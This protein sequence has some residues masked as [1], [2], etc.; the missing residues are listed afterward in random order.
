[1]KN[2]DEKTKLEIEALKIHLEHYKFEQNH[3]AQDLLTR[4]V[5]LVAIGMPFVIVA[6]N[7]EIFPLAILFYIFVIYDIYIYTKEL[8]IKRIKFSNITINIRT[9]L[10]D[11]YK[12]L[13]IDVDN[14][15]K[16]KYKLSKKHE[17]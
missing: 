2:D 11:K 5:I 15:Y 10:M 12:K 13:G 16:L 6:L 7:F 8:K 9:E 17:I 14:L 3:L 4:M 1:M